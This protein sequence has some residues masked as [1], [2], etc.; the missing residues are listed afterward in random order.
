MNKKQLI[1]RERQSIL[2]HDPAELFKK[3]IFDLNYYILKSNL[4]T[5]QMEVL[6]LLIQMFQLLSFVFNH[7]VINISFIIYT[8]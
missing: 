5:S 4:L 8:I 7:Q 3:A 2:N 6:S 1:Q